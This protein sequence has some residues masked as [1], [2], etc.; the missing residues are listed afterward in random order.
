MPFVPE[1][2]IVASSHYGSIYPSAQNLL[3]AARS[4][5]L[6]GGLVTLPLWSNTWARR[7]LRL[8][9]TVERRCIVT[10]GWPRGPVRA[11]GS[12]AGRHGCPPRPIWPPAVA[13]QHTGLTT[14]RPP[15]IRGRRNPASTADE[16]AV[17]APLFATAA[18]I[19]QRPGRLD[20]QAGRRVE[21]ASL[22]SE[23]ARDG[24]PSPRCSPIDECP[25]DLDAGSARLGQV[26]LRRPTG[27]VCAVRATKRPS[28]GSSTRWGSPGN[29]R[30]S[31]RH[32]RTSSRRAFH[33]LAATSR[34][35]ARTTGEC[36][37]LL[38]PDSLPPA[39]DTQTPAYKR[40]R[41][42]RLCA[43]SADMGSE[44][45]SADNK[46]ALAGLSSRTDSRV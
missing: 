5:G 26:R 29:R 8:P 1:P 6:G 7:I 36:A 9:L 14:H 40:G 44:V 12:Q 33:H 37:E 39:Q 19:P 20:K 21:I 11:Q 28:R 27:P 17:P 15:D 30:G 4:I 31:G 35:G 46:S 2:P 42:E 38:L 25:V 24:R 13:D 18:P 45:A 43:R 41:T 22:A 3:L 16:W 32:H 34:C 10:L 23:Q